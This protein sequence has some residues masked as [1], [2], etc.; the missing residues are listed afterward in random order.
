VGEW[1]RWKGLSGELGLKIF[2][3]WRN[4]QARYEW[5]RLGRKKALTRYFLLACTRR[6][7]RD[8]GSD[9]KGE[10]ASLV[11]KMRR[12]RVGESNKKRKEKSLPRGKEMRR[13]EGD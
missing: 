10:K 3:F 7:R 1:G 11:A 9:R 4:R 2:L 13:K 6:I 8:V 12:R 5:T